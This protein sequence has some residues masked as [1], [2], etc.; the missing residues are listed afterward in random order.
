M[1]YKI[2]WG[3][4]DGYCGGDRP[5][6]FTVDTEDYFDDEAE[7]EELSEEDRKQFFEER[8]DEEFRSVVGFEINSIKEIKGEF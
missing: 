1:K 5:Q 8:V 6:V 2:N 7:W 4:S 3:I